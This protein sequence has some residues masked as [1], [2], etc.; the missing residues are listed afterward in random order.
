ML[1]DLALAS[2]LGWAARA[3]QVVVW[4]QERLPVQVRVLRGSFN[5]LVLN[6]A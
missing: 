4:C 2:L 1:Q 5:F 3:G 6:W